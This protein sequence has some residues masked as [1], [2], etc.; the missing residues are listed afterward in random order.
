MFRSGWFQSQNSKSLKVELTKVM[1]K[2]PL[3]GS[4]SC[5]GTSWIERKQQNKTAICLEAFVLL[6]SRRSHLSSWGAPEFVCNH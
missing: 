6:N 4:A 5:S 1:Q 3:A 2:Q